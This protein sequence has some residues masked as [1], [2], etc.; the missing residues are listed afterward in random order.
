MVASIDPVARTV[1]LVS[2]P[3]DSRVRISDGHG[4]EKIN[5]AHA[6]GGPEL[7]VQTVQDDFGISIDHYVVI[8]VQGLKKLFE[9]LGPADVLGGKAHA[10]T[11]TTPRGSTWRLIQAC[12]HSHP[13]RWK[14]MCASV[15]ISVETWDAS[16]DNNGLCDRVSQ[17]LHEPQ[18]VL[19]LPQL[20]FSGKRICRDR[21]SD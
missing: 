12:R 21:S 11:R 4:M 13:P 2:I 19:K 9:I 20:F 17:K 14:S 8:D 1:G 10:P 3:R 15:M 6:L 7:A 18:V 16:K 5:A